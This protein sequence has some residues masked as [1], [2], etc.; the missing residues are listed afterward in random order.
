QDAQQAS[1]SDPETGNLFSL[2]NRSAW[3]DLLVWQ[4]MRL[5]RALDDALP[6]DVD[7]MR[8]SIAEYRALAEAIQGQ[9][10]LAATTNSP[11]A[12]SVTGQ[13]SLVAQNEATVN[14][15]VQS[16][17]AADVWLIAEYDGRLLEVISP[18]IISQEE[19]RKNAA[20]AN[21]TRSSTQPAIYPYRPD[22]LG[23]TKTTLAA[24]SARDVPITVRRLTNEHGNTKLI[25]KAV[26]KDAYLRQE[27]QVELP[28]ME[29]F[30]LTVDALNGLWRPTNDGVVLHPL[31]NRTDDFVFMLANRAKVKKSVSVRFIVP[32]RLPPADRLV[33]LP[34]GAVR[35]EAARAFLKD[36]GGE[37]LMNNPLTV[38]LPASGEAVPVKFTPAADQKPP[39]QPN[40]LVPDA[41]AAKEFA[42]K[43]LPYG[44]IVI[45]DDP[46]TNLQ[47]LR[48]V[49]IRP[50][51][52][53]N[54]L[55]ALAQLDSAG[56]LA[57][58]V[59]ATNRALVPPDG[60]KLRAKIHGISAQLES[61]LRGDIR[62]PTYSAT[63][64]GQVPPNAPDVVR[65]TIDV[66]GY[67]RAFIFEIPRQATSRTIQPVKD[68]MAVRIVSPEPQK[69]FKAPDPVVPVVMEVDAP[70]DTFYEGTSAMV[71]VGIDSDRDGELG[72]EN[73]PP[74]RILRSDRQVSVAAK[75]FTLDGTLTLD[76]KIGDFHLELTS[77]S[78]DEYAWVLGQLWAPPLEATSEPV[79]I[80]LDAFGPVLDEI[81]LPSKIEEGKDLEVVILARDL[82]RIVKVEATFETLTTGNSD[83]EKPSWTPAQPDNGGRWIAKLKTDKVFPGTN[84]TV[85]VRATDEV[86]HVTDGRSDLVSVD[87][88][89]AEPN[90]QQQ[91]QRKTVTVSGRVLYRGEP[92]RNTTVQFDPPLS[93]PIPPVKAND[94][95]KFVFRNVPP[96]TH[97]LWARGGPA[98]GYYRN[99][100][101]DIE[102]PEDSNK[103]VSVDLVAK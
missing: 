46:A 29:L 9:P 77:N 64:T 71:A 88:K 72:D 15:K 47:T 32:D 38:E 61:R 20:T 74:P 92:L 27:M 99:A 52:P 19:L 87:E 49:Q 13:L 45:I 101:I 93:P 53:R 63:L 86:G 10:N 58:Q 16:P 2:L 8:L 17:R 70:H 30:Q 85:L 50:Q 69:T 103:P 11:L 76:T 3:Y 43:D 75:S 37:A 14:V 40:L 84:Q 68:A 51:P 89:P 91:R 24:G 42:G 65:A 31:P 82:S 79:E 95:G 102:I 48:R 23:A 36:Y 100:R 97:K 66:D 34:R 41:A 21:R 80:K 18:S 67:P 28:G 1:S 12:L 60:I 73:A 56:G 7:R 33:D 94:E 55:N 25:L 22:D 90:P 98:N 4:S 83:E 35:P 62:D 81:R 59:S 44:L 5:E 6:A 39:E 78:G 26:S 96:G 57:I 54:Y